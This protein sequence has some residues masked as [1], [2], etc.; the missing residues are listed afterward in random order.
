MEVSEADRW[1]GEAGGDREPV[2]MMKKKSL[3]G[4]SIRRATDAS[5][6][7]KRCWWAA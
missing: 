3:E 6:T 1:W 7:Q 5:P 2:V 4:R